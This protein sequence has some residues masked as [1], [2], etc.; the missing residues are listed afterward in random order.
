MVCG[1]GIRSMN[2]FGEQQLREVSIA[3][4]PTVLRELAQ[5][6]LRVADELEAPGSPQRSSQWH[7]H[8]DESLCARLGC[9][10]VVV[11]GIE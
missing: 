5:F 4:S 2:D 11:A 3:A 9:D 10:V 6:L 8:I 7:R 1:Y